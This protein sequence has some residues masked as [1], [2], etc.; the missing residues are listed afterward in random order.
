MSMIRQGSALDGKLTVTLRG[1]QV[2][3]VHLD[4]RAL[5]LG[6]D[7]LG[8]AFAAAMNEALA[9]DRTDVIETIRAMTDD[10]QSQREQAQH[11]L[12]DVREELTR[13]SERARADYEAA[14]EN[15]RRMVDLM[16]D[17]RM[18]S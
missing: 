9:V 17:R 10:V 7:D 5:R 1:T 11:R 2:Q 14:V 8:A 15:H 4:P 18:I 16:M 12:V 6:A 3:N 13:S